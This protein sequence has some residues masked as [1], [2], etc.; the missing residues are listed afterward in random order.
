MNRR[1]VF[2]S[3]DERVLHEASKFFAARVG[4]LLMDMG[5]MFFDC[6]V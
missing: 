3:K 1:V 6:T 4:M 2:E 5:I